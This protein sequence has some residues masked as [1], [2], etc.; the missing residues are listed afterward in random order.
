MAGV[1]TTRYTYRPDRR[2]E[3]EMWLRITIL[4]HRYL[5]IREPHRRADESVLFA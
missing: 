1:R 3:V 4:R 5:G 2:V